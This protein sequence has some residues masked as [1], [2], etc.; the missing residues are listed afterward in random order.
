MH[1]SRRGQVRSL[2]SRDTPS[3]LHPVEGPKLAP[4]IFYRFSTVRLEA[5]TSEQE[6]REVKS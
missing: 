3:T 1:G 6:R 5:G 4:P 2:D